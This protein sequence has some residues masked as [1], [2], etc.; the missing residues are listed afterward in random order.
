MD[1]APSITR[2]PGALPILV[3][4]AT[5]S[6]ATLALVWFLN[7]QFP[8]FNIMGWYANFIIPAG[9]LIVG[10]AAGSGYGLGSWLSGSRTTGA[11]VAFVFHLQIVA[12]AG[13]QYIEFRNLDLRYEDGS[14]VGFLTYFD[15]ASRSFAWNDKSGKPGDPLGAWGYGVRALEIAGFA[16]GGI[17]VPMILWKHPYCEKCARYKKRRALGFLAASAKPPG[18][19]SGKEGAAK[20]LRESAETG[21]AASKAVEG[22]LSIAQQP[23]PTTLKEALAEIAKDSKAASKLPKRFAFRLL[24][25]PGCG[26]GQLEV[27]LLEGQGNQLNTAEMGA[28]P[29][30]PDVVRAILR[31]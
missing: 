27:Q 24:H 31:G 21:S 29:V 22:L 1:T 20:S 4:G 18:W 30:L 5:S 6:V 11:V 25:C 23:D 19:F 7:H 15:A 12:Y 14:E 10:I 16:L 8:D 28:V 26:E 9:A 13:A 17:I 2:G 3:G